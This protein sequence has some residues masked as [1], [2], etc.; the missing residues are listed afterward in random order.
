M[1]EPVAL[2]TFVT[3]QRM[4]SCTGCPSCAERCS[5]I[6]F[7]MY[8]SRICGVSTEAMMLTPF[9]VGL[10]STLVKAVLGK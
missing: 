2:I 6:T 4:K 9:V 7:T 3:L 1:V 10:S 8:G 5:S